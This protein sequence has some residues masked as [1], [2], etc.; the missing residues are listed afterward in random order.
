MG[1]FSDSSASNSPVLFIA[2]AWTCAEY[3][4]LS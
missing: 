2:S 1:F 3:L 4:A